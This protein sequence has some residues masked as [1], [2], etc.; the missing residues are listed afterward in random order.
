MIYKNYI[1]HFFRLIL[2]VFLQVVV[3]NQLNLGSLCHPYIYILFLLLLPANTPPWAVLALAFLSGLCVDVFTYNA[4][5][6]AAAS[7]ATGFVRIYLLRNLL[8]KEEFEK[9]T[10][11]GIRDKGFYFFLV[12][13]GL[14][15]LVHHLVLFFVELASFSGFVNTIL[16]VIVS[17][18]A[19]I[20][21]C[22][23]GQYLFLQAKEK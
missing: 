16:R 19:T 23:I 1:V 18:L 13:G 14:L 9:A 12:Y 17:G 4:G 21:I 2:L 8:L 6:H 11:P 7:V 10:E 3:V 20:S 15:I 5:M 22:T